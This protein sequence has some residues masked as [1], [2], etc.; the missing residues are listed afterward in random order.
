M[1]AGAA[2]RGEAGPRPAFGRAAKGT[3]RASR[4]AGGKFPRRCSPG[5]RGAGGG[6]ALPG[7]GTA[8]HGRA[9][10]FP[11]TNRRGRGG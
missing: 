1:A 3:G 11:G 2:R 5:L 7:G 8:E 10:A 6:T 4:S 9:V